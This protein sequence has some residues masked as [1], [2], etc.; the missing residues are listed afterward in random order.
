[1][2]VQKEEN[3]PEKQNIVLQN[4][5][6]NCN[7]DDKKFTLRVGD[8][9]DTMFIENVTNDEVVVKYDNGLQK[10]YQLRDGA[11]FNRSTESYNITLTDIQ[12]GQVTA[13]VLDTKCFQ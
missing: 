12:D 13:Y 4:L 10:S 1:M 7:E 9:I 5:Q 11:S 2:P 6:I 3:L 8:K